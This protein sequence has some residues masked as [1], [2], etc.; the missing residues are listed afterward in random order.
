MRALMLDPQA[1]LLD[2]PLGSLDP[3]VRYGLQDELKRIFLELGKTVI[4]VTHDLPE[5]VHFATRLVLLRAGAI[6]QDGTFADLRDRPADAFVR[7]FLQAQRRLP[8]L[9]A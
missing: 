2:E 3:I 7:E 6:V 5:A 1:L 8:E 4:L 9:S